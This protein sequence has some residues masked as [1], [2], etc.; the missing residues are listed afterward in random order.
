M[1]DLFQL[2][3][4]VNLDYD[5]TFVADLPGLRLENYVSEFLNSTVEVLNGRINLEVEYF[6]EKQVK[7]SNHRAENQT[8]E[9]KKVLKKKNHTLEVGD[10]MDVREFSKFILY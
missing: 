10:K 4:S 9:V 3:I 6:E 8:T 7:T 1:H 5:L 2:L